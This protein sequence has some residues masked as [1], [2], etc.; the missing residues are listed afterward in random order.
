M[1]GLP[2]NQRDFQVCVK[3]L[4]WMKLHSVRGEGWETPYIWLHELFMELTPE[5]S[6][7][8]GRREV[9]MWLSACASLAGRNYLHNGSW[10]TV[11]HWFPGETEHFSPLFPST[12]KSRL[13][14]VSPLSFPQH[15]VNTPLLSTYCVCRA[16]ARA[17]NT[18]PRKHVNNYIIRW[19]LIRKQREEIPGCMWRLRLNHIFFK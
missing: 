13:A 3:F 14:A 18:K 10:V 17:G 2:A 15:L 6:L 12:E 7:I 5:S 4:L 19:W 9:A 16:Y 1:S 11:A 8:C